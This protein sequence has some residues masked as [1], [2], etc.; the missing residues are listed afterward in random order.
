MRKNLFILLGL[1]VA[2]ISLANG[3]FEK[4]MGKTIPEI[5][6]AETPDA[7]QSAINQLN[8]IGEAEADRW[9]PYYYVAFGYIRM[10][11]MYE[12]GTDK[13][14]Y[15]DLALEAVDKGDQINPN[16]SELTALR[17]YVHMM[18]LVV[19]PATRGMKYSGM[20]F[21]SFQTA[22]QQNS[23]N[24]RAHY[25]LGRMQYGTAQ[26]MGNGDGGA[27]ESL[28]RAKELFE[29]EQPESP[30]AP[31]WGKETNEKTIAMICNKEGE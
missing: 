8:R 21:N 5:F 1:L 29:N 30:I 4:A 3:Q 16:D 6:K 26:F 19:D 18:R 10:S 7:L 11:D 23:E 22:V 13:D 12:S 15:L 2:T 17:G 31:Q 27:C 20:A 28:N 24:P 14:K 25:L 9:E